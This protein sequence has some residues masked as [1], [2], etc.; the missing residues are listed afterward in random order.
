VSASTFWDTIGINVHMAYYQTAYGNVSLVLNDLA[1]IGVNNVRDNFIDWGFI[2]PAYQQLAANGIK[3]DFILPVGV[4]GPNSV[5][6]T[7]YVSMVDAFATANPGS[8]SA[9]EGP[10]EVDIWPALFNGGTTFADQAALQQALDS[11]VRADS[12]LNGIPIYN[13]T[14]GYQNTAGYTQ[15]GNLSSAA[16]YANDHAY[17]EDSNTP[18]AGLAAALPY[19]S[20]DAPG[21]PTVITETGYETNSNSYSGVDELVQ[22]KLTLDTL[23]DAFKDGVAQTYL[24]ELIDEGGQ[25]FGL[26]NSDGTPKLA[27]TA[28]HNLTSILSD[29]GSTS[30]FTPGSLSYAV[31]N[32]PANAN[33]L[34]IEKSNGTFD[35]VLWAESQIWN[36]TTQSEV[37]APT[38]T[39]TVNFGQIEKSV[40]VFDP[41]IG[42]TPIATYSNVQSIQVSLTDHPLVIEISSGP[43]VTQ[44]VASPSTGIEY[45][46]NTVT[47]T[48]NLSEVVTVNGTP[49]LSLNDG[50]TAT[51]S[52]GSGTNAL[53]FTY[54]VGSSDSNV[55]AL[56]I[57]Q[58][59]LSNGAT[60]ADASGIAANLSGALVTFAGL[61]IDPPTSPPLTSIVESP[62]SGDLNAGHVVTLTVNVS[63][64]VT[65]AGGAPTL[66]LNDGGTA[67]YVGGSGTNALTFSYTVAA[68]QNTPG[69]TATAV[70]LKSATIVDGAGNAANLSL[71]GL[72]QTGPQI[73]TT[74]PS[75]SSLVTSGTG[76]TNGTG[77]LNAGHVVTLTVNL[78]EVV[79]VAGGAPTLTLNDGGTAT[80]TGGSGSN[81][82]TFSY[83]VAAGQNTSDLAVT[84]VNL[85]S[86]TVVDA[87]G[88]AAN[89][90]GAVATP[91]G[92]LQI[93]TTAPTSP[94]ISSD[95]P[96]SGTAITLTGTAE[97]NSTVTVYLGTSALGNVTT[98]GT[99][100]WS[101]TTGQLAAGSYTFTATV[102]DAAGNISALS[103]PIDPTISPSTFTIAANGTS[104][105][106]SISN[107]I[108]ILSGS[109]DTVSLTGNGDTIQLSG[110][111]DSLNIT[112]TGNSVNVT[113]FGN[114]I[115]ILG[116]GGNS[117]TLGS[118][119]N[120]VSFTNSNTRTSTTGH[121]TKGPTTANSA[122]NVS[123]AA[124]TSGNTVNATSATLLAGDSLKGA[125]S[126]TLALSGGGTINLN[127][128]SVFTGF[129]IIT[130]DNSD[131]ALILKNGTNLSVILGQGADSVLGGSTV[132]SNAT[133]ALGTGTDTVTFTT[134]TNTVCATQTTFLAGD[135]LTGAGSDTLALSGG[136]TIN[137]NAASVFTGFAKVTEDNSDTALV[138]QNGTTLSVTLG[139]GTDSVIGGS[140]PGSNA[141]VTLGAGTDSVSFTSG[142]N[143][144]NATTGSGATLLTTDSLSGAGNDMLMLTGSG[145][146]INLSQLAN[147]SGFSG[148][149]LSG[150]SDTLTLTNADL[151]V[152]RL[153][154]SHDTINLGTGID[155]IVY[156]NVNQSP[157]KNPDT[158]NAFN[159]SQDKID[160]SA[161]SGLNSNAQS[162]TI[163]FLTST[164]TNIA[165]HTI[166]V[167]TSGGN[168]VVYANATGSSESISGHHV[169]V[170]MQINLMGVTAPNSADFILYH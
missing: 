115:S 44:T 142:I 67:N 25:N 128:P 17:V 81:A 133:V 3:I 49:T 153:S 114:S 92:I 1:Y 159:A 136:G 60:V 55:S 78:S 143:T 73:D 10:N 107:E 12:N 38:E 146:T 61:Q 80:F 29:P 163:N 64:V 151:T 5:N 132:G 158:I 62:V 2:Q 53:T 149:S 109:S 147:F 96:A 166:D 70:N 160:F 121:H 52:S 48:L 125:G 77:D 137:L 11:A 68:G 21:L 103:Q 104:Q 51:Y 90:T 32:L 97:A 22:A 9:I 102:T 58:V 46:G 87:V 129:A 26:F 79:T 42:T 99:G 7:E 157:H 156:S 127:T 108:V 167:V 28:L 30:S 140:A 56:A 33:Q 165:S 118:G 164:P 34:L 71:A 4:T 19:A 74:P 144:V 110:S 65:V 117:I 120:T 93:D 47:L 85:N 20:L 123:A 124:T 111:A 101:F 63:E 36:P 161:I 112:G 169:N 95:S 39:A 152:T 66:T 86:A 59:N 89:L 8:I 148:I 130:E 13:L 122:V 106:I 141:T 69:L 155:A 6:V 134:G 31:P 139:R 88:N 116:T 135:S 75:V 76:I 138:L 150:S 54:T 23:M 18:A 16:N 162:V 72:T 100:I 24:Y 15:L 57:T 82:L 105:T 41:L 91:T 35:L 126:D 145:G 14:M 154:G 94:V 27:A 119:T 37:T 168:T 43:V 98:T 113:G 45:P 50:G 131:T 40:L 84:A 83:T 170:D